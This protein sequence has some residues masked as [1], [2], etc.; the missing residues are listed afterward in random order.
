MQE[1]AL[2]TPHVEYRQFLPLGDKTRPVANVMR[3][4]LVALLTLVVNWKSRLE[5]TYLCHR[6]LD[7]GQI[8][9]PAFL[10]QIF[11]ADAAATHYNMRTLKHRLPNRR[12]RSNQIPTNMAM[13]WW[14]GNSLFLIVA[15]LPC[16]LPRDILIVMALVGV[17]GE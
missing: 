7:I 13:L 4:S 6:L 8:G 11:R 3:Q 2:T 9:A 17:Y 14:Y 10:P 12:L 16:S 1:S 5:S 15:A